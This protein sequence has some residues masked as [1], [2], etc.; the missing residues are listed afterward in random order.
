LT[1]GREGGNFTIGY[2]S[3]ISEYIKIVK[4]MDE[5]G[6]IQRVP[7]LIKET[8][9][10]ARAKL[11]R[12]PRLKEEGESFHPDL[13]VDLKAHG[14][15]KRLI[16]EVKSLG[17]PSQLLQAIS[18]LKRM[19]ERV[20]GYPVIVTD[21]ISERGIALIKEAGMGYFDLAGN[22]YLNLGEIYIEKAAKEKIKRPAGELQRLFSRK[23]TRVIRTLLEFHERPWEIVKLAKASQVSVGHAYKVTQK[24]I[25]QGFLTEEK[26]EVRLKDAGKLLDAWADQYRIEPSKVQ[27]FYTELKDPQ[28]L[29][30]QITQVAKKRK[31]TCAFTLHAGESLVAPFTRFSEIH[32]YFGEEITDSFVKEC[33]LER[34]EFGG[35]VHLIEPYDEGVFHYLQVIDGI[36]V[37]CHTQ[38]YLDLFQHPTR[39]REAAEFLR[40]QKMKI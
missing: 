4:T 14:E 1:F 17:Y 37:V 33:G 7:Q 3:L 30:S 19:T 2:Y 5:K 9:P 26:G 8:L 39:G 22:C 20:K 36:P 28:K 25:Q 15:T 12:E 11:Q 6:L 24:L 16:I 23:A 40:R 10:F 13:V 31:S 29:M 27:S 18:L 32:F 35:T 21:Q 38:L 34:I